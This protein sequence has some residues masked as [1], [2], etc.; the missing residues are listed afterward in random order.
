MVKKQ[1]L[2]I[3]KVD[4]DNIREIIDFW[5]YYRLKKKQVDH[6]DAREITAV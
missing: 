1:S 6:D 4:K 3:Q 2:H 5:T